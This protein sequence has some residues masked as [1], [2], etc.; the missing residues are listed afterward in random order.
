M[1]VLSQYHGQLG[2]GVFHSVT[3]INDHMDP[4]D[5][6]QNGAVFDDIFKRG[7]QDLEAAVFN[8][9]LQGATDIRRA[10]VD[11]GGN[12]RGPFFKFQSPIGQSSVHRSSQYHDITG[13]T[14]IRHLRER[15]NDQEGSILFLVFNKICNQTNGLNSFTKTHLVCQDSI[16]VIVIQ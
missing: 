13:W 2:L 6:T 9:M 8:V 1:V 15:N 4:S 12:R 3:F 10:F 5:F 14:K 11:N 16:K 7:Q